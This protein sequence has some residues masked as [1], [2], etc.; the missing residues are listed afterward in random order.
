M[1]R[2]ARNDIDELMSTGARR[3]TLTD[4]FVP[5]LRK[6]WG[7]GCV[8]AAVLHTEFKARGFRGNVK[9]VRRHLQH[10]R[11]TGAP[12]ESRPVIT[13]RK[14]TGWIMHRPDELTDDERDQLHQIANRSDEIATTHQLAASF[15]LLLR[16]RRGTTSKPGPSKPKPA[17]SGRS[18]HSPQP[19]A[20]TGMRWS[21]G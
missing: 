1:R 4:A 15:T 13:P 12:T 20:A 3:S 17:T 11:V 9:T 7:K 5:Y 21:Q 2:Y 16:Q 18:A 6:R 8:N 10:W 19:C 14:V